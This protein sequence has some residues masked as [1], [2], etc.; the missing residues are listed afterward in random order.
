VTKPRAVLLA[1]V[2]LFVVIIIAIIL[3]ARQPV[4]RHRVFRTT[5]APAAPA[6]A[7]SSPNDWTAQFVA[8]ENG[9][10]WKELAALLAQIEAAHPAE[11]QRWSLGYLHARALI[12]ADDPRAAAAKLAPFLAPGHQLRDLALFHQ[13]EIDG[14]S[15]TRQQ[16]IFQY[17]QSLYRDQVIEDELDAL[18][19]PKALQAFAARLPSRDVSA[20]LAERGDLMRGLGLLEASTTDD[21]ADRASR[22]LDRPEL[23]RRMNGAELTLVGTA[24]F[25]H[26]HY[27]RAVAVLSLAPRSDQNTFDIGRAY[28]GDEKY[29]QALQTYQSG[30]A[31]TKDPKWKA[32]FLFHASRAAQLEGNDAAAEQLMTRAIAVPGRFPATS[33]ALTQRLRTRVKQRRFA[34]AAADL[35]SL[36]QLFPK[37][38]AVVEGEIGRASCRERV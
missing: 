28:F 37:D 16:L 18:R 8:L 11:Y 38:H 33:A 24:L 4:P 14:S 2:A 3:A 7:P 25:N 5:P 20:R 22:A 23:L 17:P 9:G 29:A 1:V 35:A 19:D 21:A 27:D 6:V 15:A 30:A 13:S 36:R 34:E 31:S 26:R 32:T 10:R 12:E